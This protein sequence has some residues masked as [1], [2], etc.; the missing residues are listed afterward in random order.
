MPINNGT[1]NF[2]NLKDVNIEECDLIVNVNTLFFDVVLKKM[3]KR[4][5]VSV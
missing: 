1:L 5:C 4:D 3:L 2:L